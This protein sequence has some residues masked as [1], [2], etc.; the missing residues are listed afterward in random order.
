MP[1]HPPY[2]LASTDFRFRALASH[3][4][5]S[6]LGGERE[7]A[8]AALMAARLAS[9]LLPPHPLSPAARAARATGAKGWVASLALQA[10]LRAPLARL[11]DTT[12]GESRTAVASAL[13][14]VTDLAA[15][16]LDAAS[17]AELRELTRA[18]EI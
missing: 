6:A 4:G 11:I 16:T 18:L 17:Y 7:V 2:A 5:R 12:A 9:A 10:P 8:L 1:T 3:A 14:A 15:P 13:R